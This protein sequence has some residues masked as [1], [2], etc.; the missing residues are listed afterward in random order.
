MVISAIL[1]GVL[2]LSEFST[3]PMLAA[4]ILLL[5]APIFCGFLAWLKHT[6]NR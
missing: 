5:F 4:L 3:I 1:I 2:G 6:N